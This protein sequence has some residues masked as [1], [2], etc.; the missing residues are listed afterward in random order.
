MESLSLSLLGRVAQHYLIFDGFWVG[1]TDSLRAIIHTI[2]VLEVLIARTLHTHTHTCIHKEHPST[3]I[4]CAS[5]Q[6]QRQ[7]L[8]PSTHGQLMA[9]SVR[10]FVDRKR[11][12]N[13]A[14]RREGFGE[15]V[16]A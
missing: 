10:Q 9:H 15:V 6:D 7:N 2:Q 5:Y 3:I 14:G 1:Q 16:V 12:G 11:S 4:P 13:R 8:C